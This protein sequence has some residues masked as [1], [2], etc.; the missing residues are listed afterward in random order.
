M[1]ASEMRTYCRHES[2]RRARIQQVCSEKDGLYFVSESGGDITPNAVFPVSSGMCAPRRCA[3]T[4]DGRSIPITMSRER[5][6]T[7]CSMCVARIC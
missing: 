2:P 3:H 6:L 4:M 5:L 7:S 1:C